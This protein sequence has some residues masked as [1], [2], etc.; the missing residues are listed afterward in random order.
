MSAFL[1]MVGLWIGILLIIYTAAFTCLYCGMLALAFLYLRKRYGL[2]KE[3]IDDE[4][5]DAAFTKPVS[6]IVPVHNEETGIINSIYSLLSLRYPETEIIVVND[7]STDRT[8]QIMIEH[9]QMRPVKKAM[10]KQLAAK[11]VLQIFQS[12]IHPNLWL[13]DKENGGK[14]DALNAGINFSRYPY[15]CTVDGDSILKDT[16]LLRVM[17]PI[18]RSGDKVIAAGGTVQI[19]NGFNVHY[20]S[21]ASTKLSNNALVMMQVVEYVRA[22]LMGR[23]ALSKFNLVLIISGAFS[24]F[25][26]KWVIEAGGYSTHTIGE[27]MELVVKLHRLIKDKKAD[28][29]ILFVPDPVCWTEA[30]QKLKTLRSQRRRWH[31]GLIESLWKHRKMMLNPAYGTVG[32]VSFPY[33][34][35]E[36]LAPLIELGGYLYVMY[37]FVFGDIYYEYAFLLFLLLVLYGSVLSVVSILLEAWSMNSYPRIADMLQ[38][39]VLALSETF[40][41]RPLTLLWRLEGIIMFLSKRKVWG[42]MQRVGLSKEGKSI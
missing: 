40:W 4:F 20:G 39:L 24:V 2:K 14:A 29:T 28:K 18:I 1:D 15:F 3:E 16:S 5:I 12:D 38:L 21:V 41:Y 37:A 26:K 32:M 33:F 23:I 17:E 6:I 36:C 13:L 11:H 7:G 31:Q 30:P 9:F 34:C 8:Q 22:F 19:A 25:S 42:D 10:R 27:D 35:L